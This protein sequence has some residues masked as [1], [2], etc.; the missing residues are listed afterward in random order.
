MSIDIP[1]L[2]QQWH[3]NEG[4]DSCSGIE[5]NCEAC[6][7]IT[8]LLDDLDL[9]RRHAW[10]LSTEITLRNR[11]VNKLQAKL[12]RITEAA[13]QILDNTEDVQKP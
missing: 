6:R 13:K 10:L 3:F 2:R 4:C 8:E 7:V 5:V 11:E 9:S 12:A 1:A